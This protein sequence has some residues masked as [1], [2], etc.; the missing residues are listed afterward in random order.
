[1]AT[2]DFD[3]PSW[4]TAGATAVSYL[5]ILAGLTVLLFLLPYLAF[6]AF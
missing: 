2:L 1:M 4:R 3:H 5:L 6:L